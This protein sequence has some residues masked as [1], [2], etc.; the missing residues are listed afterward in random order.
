MKFGLGYDLRNSP[1]F[2]RPFE[3]LYG[4]FLDQVEW[5]DNHGFDSV[6]L[7]EHHFS[8]DGYVPSPFVAAGAIGARTRRMRIGIS[9]ILLPLKHPVQAAEDAAVVDIITR[10]RLDLTVGA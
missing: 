1:R 10:G 7:P 2:A 8:D 6:S 4:E 9:L 3:V 5:A